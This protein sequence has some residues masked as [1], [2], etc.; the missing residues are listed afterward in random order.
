MIALSL[1]NVSNFRPRLVTSIGTLRL[2]GGIFALGLG[3]FLA[4]S[5]AGYLNFME[6]SLSDYASAEEV[7]FHAA[8][9]GIFFAVQGIIG[10]I[11]A[12]ATL[13]GKKWAWTANVIFAS[14]LIFLL[15]TDV[16]SG[17]AKSAMGILFNAFILAYMF[18]KPVKAYF[19]RIGLPPTPMSPSTAAA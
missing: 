12:F 18:A 10:I 13:R 5:P 2:L 19:G 11:I 1:P 4:S 7:A 15:A 8:F 17:Y 6:E 9:T 16:A 14:I 3:L